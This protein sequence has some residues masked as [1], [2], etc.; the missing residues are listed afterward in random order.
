MMKLTEDERCRQGGDGRDLHIVVIEDEPTIAESLRVELTYEGMRVTVAAEGRGGLQVIEEQGADLVILD[1]ML[2]DIDG[3]V[4]C[5]R[6]RALSSTLP[7]IML[8]ARG[9]VQERVQGLQQGADDYVVKPFSFDELLARVHA[10]LRR[11]G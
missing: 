9:E 2:P 10:V 4:V 5:R 11:A 3:M 1:L 8:T 7:I 6:L